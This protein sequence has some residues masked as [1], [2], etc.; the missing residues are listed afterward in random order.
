MLAQFADPAE[1]QEW[2]HNFVIVTIC[3]ELL[4]LRR[5]LEAL[6][7]AVAPAPADAAPSDPAG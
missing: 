3:E 6:A 4:Q 7:R 5:E 2:D 1:G